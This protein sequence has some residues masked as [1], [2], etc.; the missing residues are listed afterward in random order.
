MAVPPSAE[1]LFPF[2]APVDISNLSG[3][4]H[5]VCLNALVDSGQN[6]WEGVIFSRSFCDQ[7]WLMGK[8]SPN[9][10]APVQCTDP[11]AKINILGRLCRGVVGLRFGN[12]PRFVIQPLIT[13]QL[14]HH[15]NI[16][17]SFLYAVNASI[18]IKQHILLFPSF[19]IQLPGRDHWKIVGIAGGVDYL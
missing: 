17:L 9:S 18:Q 11:N 13:N 10:V 12:S 16:G 2:N 7:I 1:I 4:G 3:D 5:T 8:I 15:V 14:S 6:F 19:Q